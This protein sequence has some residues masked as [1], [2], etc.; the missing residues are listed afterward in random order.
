MPDTLPD[1]WPEIETENIVTPLAI[2]RY[3]AG[4][5][6]AKT[7][8]LIEAEVR[9]ER[10]DDDSVCHELVI[11]A[12]ALDRYEYVIATFG[13]HVK[14]VYPVAVA[15][16]SNPRARMCNSQ[17]ELLD[18]V[19]EILRTEKVKAVISSLIAQSRDA[20]QLTNLDATK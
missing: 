11:I 8:G 6:R 19:S 9:T 15:I 5:L 17:D 20:S 13:H 10:F 14:L 7:K 12:P 3:Q 18:A 4:Q 1:L 2:L 16:E